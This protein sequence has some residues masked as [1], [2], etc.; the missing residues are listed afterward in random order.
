[1]PEYNAPAPS[2]GPAPDF[3][4]RAY[5]RTAV[6]NLREGL[7][8]SLYES[9]PLSP[10]TLRALSVLEVVE[11]S[12]MLHLRN[13]LVTPTHK[14][15]RITAFLTTWA[16][17]KY[18]VA[19]AI[20]AVLSAHASVPVAKRRPAVVRFFRELA[21]RFAPIRE[22]LVA[23]RIGTDVIAVHMA[24]GVIDGWLTQAAYARI[25]ALEPH[26]ELDSTIETILGIKARH[27][28][29]FEPQAEFRL[30]QSTGAQKLARTRLRKL[31]WPIGADEVPRADTA[32]FNHHIFSSPGLATSIDDAIDGLPGL[33]GLHLIEKATA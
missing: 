6:G 26:P 1:M 20:A 14:D 3:D 31:D 21:E 19:D 13:V 15:A 24:I 16:F 23:N 2:R 33:R 5:A 29:F 9:A 17:E 30:G 12:T 8:L 27:L 28:S 22:S 4:V 7:D 32:F 10:E 25:A 18:W 11:R